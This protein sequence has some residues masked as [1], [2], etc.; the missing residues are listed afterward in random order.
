M[1]QEVTL[2]TLQETA[3]EVASLYRRAGGLKGYTTW[4]SRD[5]A[6]G[7][8]KDV[9]DLQN[10]LMAREKLRDGDGSDETLAHEL[11]DCLYSI[12]VIAKT[13]GIDLQTAFMQN[14]NMLKSK[15][16]EQL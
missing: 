11:S 15:I 4:T 14:M 2:T 9:G 10:I 7:F 16:E 5:Y 12:L 1:S 13:E 3:Y 8:S 6:Q